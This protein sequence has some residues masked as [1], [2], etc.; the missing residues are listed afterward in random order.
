VIRRA[1]LV[2]DI[3]EVSKLLEGA[4]PDPYVNGG[5]KVRYH[6]RLQKLIR[7]VPLGGMTKQDFFF[8]LQPFLATIGD[9]HTGVIT[10]KS[11]LDSRNPGGLPLFFEPTT[12]GDLYVEAVTSEEY[13]H[14]I[15]CILVSVEGVAFEELV[16]RQSRRVGSENA[17]QL[18]VVLGK[19]G[20]LFYKN[21]LKQLIPEWKAEEKI[22]VVLRHPNGKEK[23]Y[24]FPPSTNVTYPLVERSARFDLPKPQNP[25]FDFRFIGRGRARGKDIALL[26]I[27]NMM[28][29]REA[30]EYWDA[31]GS[32]GFVNHGRQV[33]RIYN[34]REAPEDY[35]QVINGIPAI[36][37][38][39]IGLFQE[40]RRRKSQFL[41]VDLRNN[42]GGN[43]SMILI[44]LY[45]LVGFDK[46]VS[47]LMKTATVRKLSKY[48]QETSAK[49]I[50]LEKIPYARLVPLTIDDYDYSGDPSFSPEEVRQATITKL[51]STFEKMPSFHKEFQSG[52][53]E[54]FYQPKN[55]IVLCSSHTFSSGFNLM[56][57]LYR[58]GASIVG[59][60]SG[61]AGNSF[62][63]NRT[64]E[65][66]H[67]KL[68]IGFSTKYFIAF[69]DDPKTGRVLMPQYPMTY[70]KLASYKFDKNA[71][72]LYA[73]EIVNSLNKG[74]K[75]PKN[76]TRKK[77]R[78][79]L[80]PTSSMGKMRARS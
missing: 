61:Q 15:G 48:L 66:S 28:T 73:L 19:D 56:T 69:P 11:S 74:A 41:I 35:G 36:T 14:L 23:T 39:F 3:Q 45:F 78:A 2:Q 44:L 72:L 17:Y 18:L 71:T 51:A 10:D 43:D 77:P 37:E 9:G 25:F 31:T 7:D 52:K 59:I 50:E 4:H 33:F 8:Y 16:R 80:N 1:A 40:M 53:F 76:H 21:Y 60:P 12:E 46:T 79:Q 54:R 32:K 57:Y 20:S 34:N 55:I 30:F 63:D 65:L 26:R 24:A 13:S 64:F 38:T 75:P 49:G 47:L 22:S 42:S 68:R 58:I 29:Y 67:S 62:G 6:R 70:E 27:E 5:G